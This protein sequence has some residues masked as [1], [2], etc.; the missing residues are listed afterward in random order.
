VFIRLHDDDTV[1]VLLLSF[2]LFLPQR[3]EEERKSPSRAP[4]NKNT[5]PGQAGDDAKK[6]RKHIRRIKAKA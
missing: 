1:Q 5:R 4:T 3:V 6:E 2:R